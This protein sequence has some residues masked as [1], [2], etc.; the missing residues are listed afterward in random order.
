MSKRI[1]IIGVG[2]MGEPMAKNLIDAGYEV[3]AYDINL[4]AVERVAA[5][6]GTAASSS[7]EAAASRDMVITMLPYDRIV[8]EAVM[9]RDG[10]MEGMDQGVILI[11][12][13]TVSPSTSRKIAEVCPG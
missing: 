13:S 4:K 7:K 12:M 11:D 2:I 10:A 1:G 5:Y 8:E 6:G 3:R 9:G